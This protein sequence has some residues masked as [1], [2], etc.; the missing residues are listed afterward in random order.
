[1]MIW[2]INQ[3]LPL[4]AFTSEAFKELLAKGPLELMHISDSLASIL[5]QDGM[6]HHTKITNDFKYTLPSSHSMKNYPWRAKFVLSI[7]WDKMQCLLIGL[8]ATSKICQV[9]QMKV[10]IWNPDANFSRL[11][12]TKIV[13]KKRTTYNITAPANLNY[14]GRVNTVRVTHELYNF[15]LSQGVICNEVP[16]LS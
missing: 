12:M 16:G 3:Q 13:G 8:T 14:P 15:F 2:L 4:P 11:E 9:S 1:M 10:L 7:G 6:A 5:T